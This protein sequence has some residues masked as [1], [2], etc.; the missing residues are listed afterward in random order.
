LREV[1]AER[2]ARLRGRPH[3]SSRARAWAGTLPSGARME[4]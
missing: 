3:G 2:Q 1:R 4:R